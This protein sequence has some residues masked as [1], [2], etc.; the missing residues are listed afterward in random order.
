MG[1]IYIARQGK[2]LM[3][4]CPPG[5]MSQE[6]TNQVALSPP[7]HMLNEPQLNTP[8][9]TIKKV[10]GVDRCI[11]PEIEQLWAQG[12]RTTGCCCGHNDKDLQPYIGVLDDDIERMKALDYKVQII[13][14]WP[15][16]E[17]SFAP[18]SV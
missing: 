4:D 2:N 16:R 14:S 9:Y 8:C 18:K 13:P 1:L 15:D 5:T 12:I 10:I 17:D 11:A 3:C 7:A 6:Y